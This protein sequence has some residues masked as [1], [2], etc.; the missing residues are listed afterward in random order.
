MQQQKTIRPDDLKKATDKM[1]KVVAEGSAEVK[2]IVDSA[3]K[4]LES[5]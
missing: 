1:E 5:G 4:M 3:K 2:K